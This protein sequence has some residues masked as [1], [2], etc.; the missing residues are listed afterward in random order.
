MLMRKYLF[1]TLLLSLITVR[2][3][4]ATIAV[5]TLDWNNIITTICGG[6]ICW[7]SYQVFS[8]VKKYIRKIDNQITIQNIRH[9]ALTQSLAKDPSHRQLILDYEI[10]M[11]EIIKEYKF[12]NAN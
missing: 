1:L 10:R 3:Y 7:M 4:A 8:L 5:P 12:I 2:I 9:E 11:E 6:F